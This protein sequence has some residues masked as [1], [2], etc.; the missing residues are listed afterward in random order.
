MRTIELCNTCI[1]NG[2]CCNNF[3]SSPCCYCTQV[4]LCPD[5]NPK[6]NNYIP[7][8]QCYICSRKQWCLK[9]Y[10]NKDNNCE[11]WVGI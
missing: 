11:D 8:S 2:K 7:T 6:A 5:Q 1:N 3:G 10:T 4:R 9:Q